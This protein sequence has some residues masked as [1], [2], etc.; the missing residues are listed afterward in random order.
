[1]FLQQFMPHRVRFLSVG[2]AGGVLPS[3]YILQRIVLYSATVASVMVPDGVQLIYSSNSFISS[4]TQLSLCGTKCLG[5]NICWTILVFH[6][7]L[8]SL[9]TLLSVKCLV[10]LTRSPEIMPLH[11]QYSYLLFYRQSYC[12]RLYSTPS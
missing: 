4:T 9:L 1:M 5:V 2:V 8:I 10:S 7:F 12:A 3:C 11:Y 6:F